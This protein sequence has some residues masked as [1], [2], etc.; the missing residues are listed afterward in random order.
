MGLTAALISLHELTRV[1]IST[2]M[3][4]SNGGPECVCIRDNK[5][6]RRLWYQP[7]ESRRTMHE[8]RP[9]ERDVR[10]VCLLG[11]KLL[12]MVSPVIWIS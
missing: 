1:S 11:Y 5:T 6:R 10:R 3:Q 12:K 8:S 9:A 2:K 7:F 4:P